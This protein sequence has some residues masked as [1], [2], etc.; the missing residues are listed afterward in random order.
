M[1]NTFETNPMASII[2][3]SNLSTRIPLSA[4]IFLILICVAFVF[5]AFYSPSVN[6]SMY[7]PMRLVSTFSFVAIITVLLGLG[8]MSDSLQQKFG[9]SLMYFLMTALVTVIFLKT[10]F[11]YMFAYRLKCAQDYEASTGRVPPGPQHKTFVIF[12]QS[13]K[14]LGALLIVYWSIALAP[15]LISPFFQLFDSSDPIIYYVGM[16][17]LLGAAMWPAEISAYF[18]LAGGACRPSGFIDIQTDEDE[19]EEN[20]N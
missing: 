8:V 10:F 2:G 13:L 18:D 15:G 1:S 9:S 4:L 14:I 17:V 7:L 3:E 6:S 19:D 20:D 12:L 11:E 16:G 5:T